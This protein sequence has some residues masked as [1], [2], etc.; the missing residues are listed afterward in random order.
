MKN[1]LLVSVFAMVA[2][3]AFTS[4]ESKSKVMDVCDD[5]IKQSLHKSARS[6]VELDGQ[7]LTIT[8]FEFLGGVNDNRMVH[9]AISFGNGV[10]EPKKVDTLVYEYGEWLENNTKYSL[11]VTPPTGEKY[12]LWYQGNAFLTSD[13]KAIGGEGTATTARVEKWEKV[14]NTLPNTAWETLYRGEF[15]MDSVY[16]DSIRKTWIPEEYRVKYDTFK[17]FDHMDTLSADTTCLFRY[18]FNRDA[19]SKKTTG[20]YYS[21]GVRS[22]YDRE[23]QKELILIE[24]E[25]EGS[26]DWFFG[27][28][29]SDSKFLITALSNTEGVD[30][31]KLSIS[32]YKLD[33]IGK[34]EEFLLGGFTYKPVTLP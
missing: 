30:D 18:E 24:T 13:G 26:F 1:K 8:E 19:D 34:P 10:Y 33:S 23:E 4:C 12:T 14:L 25:I 17:I 5:L 7:T 21:K 20:R 3:F 32:K 31:Q 22:T 15:V 2:A 11:Y 29:S 6:L 9:R 27:D 28:V 16:R